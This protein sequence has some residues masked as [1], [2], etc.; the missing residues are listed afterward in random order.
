M[1]LKR[2]AGKRAVQHKE[3]RED[4]RSRELDEAKAESK[5]LEKA[6]SQANR[7]IER[8]QHQLGPEEEAGD[9]A[10]PSEKEER[11]TSQVCQVCRGPVVSMTLPTGTVVSGCKKCKTTERK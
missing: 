10:M 5:K 3:S 8:L 7:L 9:E 6:L 1:S 11:K 2:G 4:R